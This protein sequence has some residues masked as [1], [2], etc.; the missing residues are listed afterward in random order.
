MALLPVSVG[1]VP[2]GALVGT[3]WALVRLLRFTMNRA[4]MASEIGGL[5]EYHFTYL[6]YVYLGAGCV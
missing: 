4:D 1:I 3:I 2:A 6:A 5:I